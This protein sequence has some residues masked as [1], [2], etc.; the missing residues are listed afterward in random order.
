MKQASFPNQEKRSHKIRKIPCAMNSKDKHPVLKLTE[1]IRYSIVAT[2]KE[3]KDFVKR[4]AEIMQLEPGEDAGRKILVCVKKH[5]KGEKKMVIPEKEE[6]PILCILN[7]ADNEEM[8]N[9]QTEMIAKAVVVDATNKGGMLIHGALCSLNG[10]G[11]IMAGPGTVGKSTASRRLPDPWISYCDDATIILPDCHGRFFAHPWPTWSR[12][13]MQGPGG[14]WKVEEAIPLEAIYF[15]QQSPDDFV[16]PV[17][18]A[19]AKAMIIDTVEHVTR[20]NMFSVMEKQKLVKNFIKRANSLAESVPAFRLHLSLTGEFWKEMEKVLPT[21]IKHE[22]E[23]SKEYFGQSVIDFI[24][25]NINK[26]PL[27]FVYRGVSMNPTFIEP[28]MITVFPYEKSRI[29]TGDVI[30]YKTTADENV[31]VHRIIGINGSRIQT[32]G[33]NNAAPDP[34]TIEAA[35]IIGRVCESR[36]EGRLRRIHGGAAGITAMYCIRMRKPGMRFMSEMLH[37]VYNYL[38]HSGIMRKLLPGKIKIDFAVFERGKI[39][40]PKIIIS[41]KTI[42]RYNPRE[43]RWNIKRPYRFFIDESRLPDVKR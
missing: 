35:D 21:E 4:L 19:H 10:S 6:D 13:Y 12:F 26:G 7:P 42:G 24:H 1:S 17:D 43:Q 3:A 40:Y 14:R 37:S 38:S 41:G 27:Y 36:K 30:C 33:D 23:T 39:K 8:F 22:E 18:R 28:E 16:A 11:V 20:S 34:Y 2:D 29:R 9:I 32:K 31:I 15:L 5:K 25:K